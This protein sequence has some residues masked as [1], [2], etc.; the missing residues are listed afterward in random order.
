MMT[1]TKDCLRISVRR[2]DDVECLLELVWTLR[3]ELRDKVKLTVL[4]SI[5]ALVRQQQAILSASS[6]LGSAEYGTEGE[7]V[8]ASEKSCSDDDDWEC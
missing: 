6:A 3:P 4:L 7:P 1:K 2:T 5:D 8:K